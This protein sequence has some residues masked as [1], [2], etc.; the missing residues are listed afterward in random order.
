M[1]HL[2][3]V[4]EYST[5]YSPAN[6]SLLFEKQTYKGSI[7]GGAIPD[8]VDCIELKFSNLLIKNNC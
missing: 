2:L 1:G 8:T 3:N 4:I 6:K 5:S 7:N